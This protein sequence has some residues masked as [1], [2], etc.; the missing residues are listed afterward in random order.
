MRELS[1]LTLEEVIPFFS[2]IFLVQVLITR[3]A[4]TLGTIDFKYDC[5]IH[6]PY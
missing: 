5:Y 2:P 6:I 4:I 3:V 1:S